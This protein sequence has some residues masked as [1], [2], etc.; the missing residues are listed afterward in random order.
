MSNKKERTEAEN[1]AMMDHPEMV[2]AR[3]RAAK[4][5]PVKRKG[6]FGK[7]SGEEAMAGF[8]QCTTA[9]GKGYVVGNLIGEGVAPDMVLVCIGRD[10]FVGPK[11]KGPCIHVPM[12][13]A[14]VT[15]IGRAKEVIDET[16]EVPLSEFPDE[17][18]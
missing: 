18:V 3:E 12:K 7:S 2:A 17:E 15:V 5:K 14:D 13:R 11:I 4:R 1:A 10:D 9:Q 8:Y 16:V 6:A